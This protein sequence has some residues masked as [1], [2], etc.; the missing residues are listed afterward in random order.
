MLGCLIQNFPTLH[1]QQSVQVP[2]G[3]ACDQANNLIV[4]CLSQTAALRLIL[5]VFRPQI[6]HVKGMVGPIQAGDSHAFSS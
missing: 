4:S 2:S 3:L 6:P 1:R 5:L